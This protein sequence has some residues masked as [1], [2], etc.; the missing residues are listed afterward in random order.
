MKEH[1]DLAVLV[2]VNQGLCHGHLLRVQ[3][4]VHCSDHL[5]VT[6]RE[7]TL[8]VRSLVDELLEKEVHLLSQ[9]GQ[10]PLHNR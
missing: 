3:S 10:I 1:V 9:L 5:P 2:L 8:L 6:R 4:E 7:M